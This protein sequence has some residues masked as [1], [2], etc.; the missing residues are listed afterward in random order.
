[1]SLSQVPSAPNS[2]F[3]SATL[4]AS[5]RITPPD[6]PEDVRRL[7]FTMSDP[8]FDGRIGQCVRVRAPGQFGQRWH[9]RLYSIADLDRSDQQRTEFELLVRRCHS[10]DEF[11]GERYDGPASKMLCD[12]PAGGEIQFTGPF[13]HPFPIPAD[14]K[15]GLLMIGMGTGIAPFRGLVRRIY[16]EVGG[17][18][19]PVRLFYGARSGLEMLYQNEENADLGLYYDQPT[20]QAFK[21]VS[22]RPH[23]G[24]APALDKALL[25]H[26]AEVCAMLDEP[27]THLFVAGPEAMLPQVEKALAQAMGSPENWA[28]LRAKLVAGC[29]WHDVLY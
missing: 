29:R 18:D 3:W 16:D 20:F 10:I 23:F 1:M 9:E 6:S 13:G 12:L 15:A 5:E 7:R 22:P 21:A 27:R 26:A 2:R 19:G 11:N 24:E 14:H 17:W 4:T 8:G 28:A 25:E